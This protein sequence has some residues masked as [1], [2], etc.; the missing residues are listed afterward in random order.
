MVG[1]PVHAPVLVVAGAQSEHGEENALI[2]VLFDEA[3]QLAL[4]GGSDVEITIGGENH[5]IIG[6]RVEL[7][8][9]DAVGQFDALGPGGGAAGTQLINGLQQCGLL[10]T[11]GGRQG[12]ARLSGIGDDGDRIVRIELFDQLAVGPLQH[13]QL[14]GGLH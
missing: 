6:L 3:D 11:R 13:R 2:P 10:L 1:Q 9:G 8:A 14:V 12:Q 7:L 5:T 4:T